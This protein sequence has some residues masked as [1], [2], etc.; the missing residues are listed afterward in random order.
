[1]RELDDV[2]AEAAQGRE[3]SLDALRP[4]PGRLAAT[5]AGVRRRRTRRHLI[6]AAVT[7]PLVAALALGGWVLGGSRLGTLPPVDGPIATA[8]L[9]A[10]PAIPGLP[11]R[12]LMPDGLLDRTGPGWVLVTYAAPD[13]DQPDQNLDAVLLVSPDDVV[14]QVALLHHADLA[15]PTRPAGYSAE[16]TIDAW[17]PGSP[18]AQVTVLTYQAGDP[19]NDSRQ[20]R[21]LDLNTGELGDAAS[22]TSGPAP[23][24]ALWLGYAGDTPMWGSSDSTLVLDTAEGPVDTGVPASPQGLAVS[25][26]DRDVLAS[27]R[28]VEVATGAV[29]GSL[30]PR[31]GP[32]GYCATLGWWD[33]RS[34][35]LECGDQDWVTGALVTGAGAANDLRLVAVPIDGLDGAGTVL[36]GLGSAL[37]N[38][39][40]AVR[41]EDGALAVSGA[42]KDASGQYVQ[43]AFLVHA[44]GSMTP[45]APVDA[46]S[47]L[48]G[49]TVRAAG[50]RFVVAR[51]SYSPATGIESAELTAYDASGGSPRVLLALP[52]PDGASADQARSAGVTSWILA[53]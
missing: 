28:V 19:G 15:S 9:V 4:A 5:V 44:D 51:S 22:D 16:M 14:F 33:A 13:P 18:S 11:D 47:D 21:T 40:G 49:V 29:L 26:D 17:H 36:G 7:V 43:G 23:D 30:P 20:A 32:N 27:N 3:Q 25:P 39:Y 50:S 38:P 42:A 12:F 34:V 35:L 41:L 24:G 8:D 45:L 37:L 46:R 1:M 53:P 10:A 52:Q 31:D 48:T 2:L 6:E